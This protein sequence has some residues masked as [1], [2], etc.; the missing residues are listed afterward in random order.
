MSDERIPLL[1]L[2][3]QYAGI[4]DEIGA[5]VQRVIESQRFVLGPEV[6]ALEQE[7]ASYCDA[8]FAVACGSGSDAILLALM[9]HGVGRGDQVICPAHTF[10]STAGSIARLGAEPVFADIDPAAFNV[11]SRSVRAAAQRCANL[12]AIVP[13]H[14]YGRAA[15]MEELLALGEELGV[16]ILEDAAQAIGARDA[17]GR[18][19]GSRGSVG[20][21][22]FYPSKN[23]GGYGDGGMLTTGDAQLAERMRVLRTHGAQSEW[24]HAMVGVNSR[25]DAIQAAVLRV[26]LR[27]LD[28]WTAARREAATLYGELLRKAGAGSGPG[29]FDELAL[30]ARLPISEREPAVHVFHQYVIRVPAGARDPLREFLRQRGVETKIYYPIPLHRQ[31]CFQPLGTA[32]GELPASELAAREVLALPIFPELGE[33]RIRAVVERIQLFFDA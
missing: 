33:A 29:E 19:V 5:A 17:Q 26:K 18:R 16:P 12:K 8:D 15:P 9:V 24:H 32:T 27:H 13:V 28:T 30:P 10:F 31:E 11:T 3:A 14:L 2:K 25:L 22:S 4:A 23:L 7:I 1:D 20:C 21:F 6:E